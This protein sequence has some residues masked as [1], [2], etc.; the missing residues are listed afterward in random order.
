MCR[1]KNGRVSP[2]ITKWLQ[3]IS[4]LLVF[5]GQQDKKRAL[6]KKSW[7]VRCEQMPGS[8]NVLAPPLV[9]RSK[10]VFPSL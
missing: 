3:K 2:R 4:V 10:I 5:V 6:D 8:L 1:F 7:P 9:E